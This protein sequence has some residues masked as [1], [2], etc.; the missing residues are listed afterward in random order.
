[1]AKEKLTHINNDEE[2]L[3]KQL[4]SKYL[5][6]WPLFILAMLLGGGAAYTYLRYKT[7]IYEAQSSIIIKDEKKGAEASKLSEELNTISSK[8]L[9]ENEIEVLRSRKLMK[10]VAIEQA[11]YAPV[12]SKGRVHPTSAYL[13]SPIKIVAKNP[14]SIKKAD[15]LEFAYDDFSKQVTINNKHTYKLNEFANT[16][17][18]ILKFIPNPYYSLADAP[19]KGNFYFSLQSVN[20]AASDAIRNLEVTTASKMSTIIELRLKDELPERAEDILNGLLRAYE[21]EAIK[22]KNDIAK[23]TLAFVE[24]R[25]NDVGRQMDSIQKKVQGYKTGT[26]AV[27]IGTQGQLFLQ[28]VSENDQKLS[29]INS[30]LSVLNQAENFVASRGT[31]GAIVPSTLGVNDPML[32]QMMDKL[33]SSELEVKRLKKTYG[34]NH[35][36]VEAV[37]DE[38]KKIRPNILE[39]IKSQKKN[40]QATRSI[41]G[42]T[43]GRYN[44]MLSSVPVK[45]RALLDLTRNEST[46]NSVYQFLLQKKEETI[47]SLSSIISDNKVVDNAHAGTTPVS[48][49]RKL[50]YGIGILSLLFLAMMFIGIREFFTA[51]ILYR[52]EIEEMTSVPVI[53]EIS[54][55]RMKRKIIVE[56]GKRTYGTEEF[57]KIRSSLSFL[58]INNNHRKLLITSSIKGEGKSFVSANLAISVASAGTKTVLVDMDFNNPTIHKIFKIKPARGVVD[59]LKDDDEIDSLIYKV[60]GYENLYYISSGTRIDGPSEL[61]ANGKVKKLIEYLD[62]KFDRVIIDTSPVVLITD[63]YLLSSLCDA[64]LYVIRHQY[65]PKMIVKRIDENNVINPIHNPGIIFNGVKG[66]GVFRNSYGHGYGYGYVYDL[67]DDTKRSQITILREKFKKGVGQI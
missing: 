65:T 1:M 15:K 47:L 11:L 62:N 57:R 26:G 35:P 27:D 7:P 24:E 48:P 67:D 32:T 6:Y 63:A 10:M 64:T 40:L 39:N 31:Q 2:N 9:V 34:E 21:D 13:S 29:T 14:D 41:I 59:Y 19:D 8:Q 58:S 54:Q 56:P 16:P 60:E 52:K 30:Q 25:L 18:G 3:L 38:I 66:R 51:R 55:D 28:N 33:Y 23:S 53:A 4:S 12:F 49:N 46:L 22:S 44:A 42:S 37:E 45:E 17:W 36:S 61:L 20:K 5:P 43:N 50:V